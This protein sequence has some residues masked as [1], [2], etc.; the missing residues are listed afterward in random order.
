MPPRASVAVSAVAIDASITELRG[1]PARGTPSKATRHEV[2]EAG[3]EQE[4]NPTASPA[5]LQQGRDTTM[6]HPARG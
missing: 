3:L 1:V 2:N 4:K 6:Q 5:A